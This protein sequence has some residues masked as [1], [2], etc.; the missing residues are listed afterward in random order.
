M[1]LP[2]PRLIVLVLAVVPLFLAGAFVEPLI[3]LALMALLSIAFVA[4]VDWLVVG[5]RT[6]V[7]IE[8]TLPQRVSIAVPVRFRYRIHNESKVRLQI[9]FTEVIPEDLVIEPEAFSLDLGPGESRDLEATLTATRRGTRKLTS[10]DVRS[11]PARGLLIRQTTLEQ[12]QEVRVYPNLVNIKRYDLMLRR[13]VTDEQGLARVWR[14]GTGSEFESLRHYVQGDD[15]GRIDW[16]A[17][18][19]RGTAIVRNFEAEKRQS[20]IVALDLGR[21]SAAESGGM[22][23][24]DVF[25]NATL[26]LAYVCL[27]QGDWFSLMAFDEKV[28][29]Y[30]P[31]IRGIKSIERVADAL[32]D[33]EPRLV[34]ADYGAACRFLGMRNRKRSLMV[35]M[36]DVIDK[37]ANDVMI[38]YMARHAR[39]HLPL[40]VTLRD[41]DV[42]AVAEA[43]LA[44]AADPYVKAVA[45]D[46]LAVRAEALVEMRRRGVGVIDTMPHALTPQLIHRYLT[47]KSTRRL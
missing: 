34:E 17:T 36:T 33:L 28:V 44:E 18:A 20:V 23:R 2:S 27:R 42:E 43:A 31:P 8:R 40:V 15:L 22:S 35:L 16:K 21:A 11:L 7:T 46:S 45:L 1:P 32:C 14:P 10:L 29:S 25:V 3:A 4:A 12:G 41:P 24:L 38:A 5:A 39:V 26:M 30:L 9:R 37:D 19:R 6:R 13:G 47:I